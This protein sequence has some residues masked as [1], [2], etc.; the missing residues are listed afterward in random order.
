MF[1]LQYFKCSVWNYICA[2]YCKMFGKTQKKT[3]WQITRIIIWLLEFHIHW[4]F[5]VVVVIV[6]K[7]LYEAWKDLEEEGCPA[8]KILIIKAISQEQMTEEIFVW[9]L[10]CPCR[11]LVALKMSTIPYL[12]SF[13]NS[14]PSSLWH[15]LKLILGLTWHRSSPWRT[16]NA[17]R[18]GYAKYT[19][20]VSNN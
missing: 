20:K 6:L 19:V 10:F 17:E 11:I 1:F 12:V 13:I 18:F 7:D 16:A 3:Q 8:R 15:S 14:L 5:V 4:W 2:W 9:I